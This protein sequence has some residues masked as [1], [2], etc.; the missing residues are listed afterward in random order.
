MRTG[1]SQIALRFSRRAPR[2]AGF[3]LKVAAKLHPRNTPHWSM[4]MIADAIDIRVLV[5]AKLNN[6]M[7]MQVVWGDSVGTAIRSEGCYEPEVVSVFLSHIKRG[8]TVIDVGAHVGQ[9]SLLAAGIGCTVHSFEPEPKTFAILSAN[10]AHNKL[11]RV[12]LNQC[13][14]AESIYSARLFSATCDNIGATSLVPNKYTSEISSLVSCVTL[15]EY[16]AKMGNPE[17]S[18]IKIDVEGAEMGVLLGA[19]STLSLYHPRLVIEF[20]ETMQGASGH[21]CSDLAN[22]LRSFGYR[23]WRIT[24]DGLIPY[25]PKLREEGY[26]NVFAD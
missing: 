22:L 24:W 4:R 3:G 10:V 14:L 23:L 2:I 20:S 11:N 21:T 15:D 17:I 12:Y 8:Q 16:L 7:K 9:Y 18:F 13:A 25:I 26:F 5:P 6:G 19:K 1:L